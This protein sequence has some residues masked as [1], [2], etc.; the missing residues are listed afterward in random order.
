MVQPFAPCFVECVVSEES[1]VSQR[2]LGLWLRVP[3]VR[4]GGRLLIAEVMLEFPPFGLLYDLAHLGGESNVGGLQ[5]VVP[6]FH[7]GVLAV[8]ACDGQ[9]MLGLAL[10]DLLLVE[11]SRTV[12]AGL[13]I[14]VDPRQ[15]DGHQSSYRC[16]SH[17]PKEFRLHGYI[18]ACDRALATCG[19]DC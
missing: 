2:F 18:L 19:E 12:A 5:V 17:D 1:K 7:S 15:R 9:F 10:R 16:A 11:L 13:A 6:L 4:F 3:R 8:L 14:Q